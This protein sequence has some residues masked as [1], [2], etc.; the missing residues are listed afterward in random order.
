MIYEETNYSAGINYLT[1][2]FIREYDI[3]KANI[4]VLYSKGLLDKKT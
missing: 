4:N 2:T 3:S 1:N